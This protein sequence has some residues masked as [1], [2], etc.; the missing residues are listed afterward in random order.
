MEVWAGQRLG[1]R[2][3]RDLQGDRLSS[4]EAR[5]WP[6]AT[7]GILIPWSEFGHEI[8]HV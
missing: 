2:R 6:E 7:H 5:G 8:S 3:C 1:Q 4:R